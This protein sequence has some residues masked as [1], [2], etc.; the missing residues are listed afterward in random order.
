MFKCVKF[1]YYNI[2]AAENAIRTIYKYIERNLCVK[3]DNYQESEVLCQR[4]IPMTPLRIEP[5]TFRL[6]AQY[7]NQLCHHVPNFFLIV[8]MRSAWWCFVRTATCSTVLCNITAL[9]GQHIS[10]FCHYWMFFS[11]L[12]DECNNRSLQQAHTPR[13]ISFHTFPLYYSLTTSF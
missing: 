5:A 1:R 10:V 6:V 9:F 3:L 11:V 2:E 4:K 12:P 7:I 13:I 8:V